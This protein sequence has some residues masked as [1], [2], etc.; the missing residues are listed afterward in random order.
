MIFFHFDAFPAELWNSVEVNNNPGIKIVLIGLDGLEWSI[1]NGL[2]KQ[3][4]MSTFAR[5]I[6]DGAHGDIKIFEGVYN[7]S[8]ALWTSLAT[9]KKPSVHGILDHLVHEDNKYKLVIP[10]TYHRK[11]KALWNILS[12]CGKKVGVINYYAT[13]PPEEINGFI[14]SN[15][16][17]SRSRLEGTDVFPSSLANEINPL[18]ESYGY[19][20]NTLMINNNNFFEKQAKDIN[21]GINMLTGVTS[22]LYQ[23]F[24]KDL[25][26][27]MIYTQNTDIAQHWFWKFMEPEYFWHPAWGLD[28]ENI[29]KYGNFIKDMYQKVD[30]MVKE[31]IKY[32]DEDTIVIICS[33]HGFQRANSI[34]GVHLSNLDNLLEAIGFLSFRDNNKSKDIDFSKTKAYHCLFPGKSSFIRIGINLKG[35]EP[36]GIVKPGKD[37]LQVK[38]QLID[39]LSNLR[40]VETGE[41]LFSEV[42]ELSG[43][44]GDIGISIKNNIVALKQHVKINKDICPLSTFFPFYDL[45]GEHRNHKGVLIIYGKNIKKAKLIEDVHIL[46]ITPTV[47]YLLGLPIAKDMEGKVLTQAIEVNF[48]KEN[49][50]KFID[51]YEVERAQYRKE[52][53]PQPIDKEQ[54]ERLKSLGYAQ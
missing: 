44:G 47:L 9:G 34:P 22:Y 28:P 25:D 40:V 23:K 17:L 5:L 29:E 42:T 38:R 6:Q 50:I 54:L 2:V 14:V 24:N 13:W 36:Q 26:L 8:P 15:E 37:Y 53:F 35:R 31:I 46:D 3:G 1:I 32:I 11:V 18:I 19:E 49:P 10:R 48:L 21:V 51:T 16:N 33:D 20:N 45:S 39:I 27:L 4:K 7:S 30:V 43:G 12:E 52:F 41:K